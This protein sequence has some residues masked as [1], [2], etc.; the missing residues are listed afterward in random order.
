MTGNH[1]GAFIITTSPT[2]AAAD[3]GMDTSAELEPRGPSVRETEPDE[4]LGEAE[5]LVIGQQRLGHAGQWLSLGAALIVGL[6]AGRLSTGHPTAQP[7]T[8]ASTTAQHPSTPHVTASIAPKSTADAR[9]CLAYRSCT[10]RHLSAPALLRQ[11]NS[12]FPDLRTA[13]IVAT[14]DE[15][16]RDRYRVRLIATLERGLT[17]EVIADNAAKPSAV[18]TPWIFL[19]VGENRRPDR[20][21]RT[22]ISNSPNG[23]I[24]H[25][26]LAA[27]TDPH[28]P[29]LPDMRCN[30]CGHTVPRS[31]AAARL[32]GLSRADRR[33]LT[34][35]LA[36]GLR[37][38]NDHRVL[39]QFR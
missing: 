24:L 22:M 14:D 8:R 34:A 25:I 5:E 30:S 33:D 32:Q 26:T 20:A 39:N 27:A 10:S 28:H 3:G 17:L 31:E 19:T 9:G 37:A 35:A 4:V 38:A 1:T 6:L 12:A 2:G 36:I 11:L 29:R 7:T 21:S 15:F 23:P 16:T 13:S 18:V